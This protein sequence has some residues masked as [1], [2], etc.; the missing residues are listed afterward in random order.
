MIF[1]IWWSET[2]C[3]KQR[4]EAMELSFC[5]SPEG[6]GKMTVLQ[7]FT[8]L[9]YASQSSFQHV[10]ADCKLLVQTTH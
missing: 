2:D 4:G 9:F 1:G 5:T 7:G 8:E 6:K 10:I 3:I